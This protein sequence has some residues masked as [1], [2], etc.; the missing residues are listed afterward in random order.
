MAVT[1]R[2]DF[3]FIQPPEHLVVIIADDSPFIHM[4]EPPV[5]RS[6]RIKLTEEQVMEL[7]LARTGYSRGNPYYERISCCFLE[8]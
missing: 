6:V 4:Q 5:K 1:T 2:E 8:D 7:R 3:L